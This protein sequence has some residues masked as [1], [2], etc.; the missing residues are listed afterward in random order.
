MKQ[1]FKNII[2]GYRSELLNGKFNLLENRFLTQPGESLI[3]AS[4]RLG[5]FDLGELKTLNKTFNEKDKSLPQIVRTAG[6][7]EK[8]SPEVKLIIKALEAL[9]YQVRKED[10]KNYNLNIVGIRNDEVKLNQFNDELWVFWKFENVWKL[11]KYKITTNPG[12][13]W[14][15]NPMN[16]EGT[17]ILKEGQY[18]DSHIF[19]KHKGKYEALVQSKPLTVIRDTNRDTTVDFNSNKTQTGKFGIN[20]HRSNENHES[21]SVDKWS[22]GCQVFARPKE[23]NDFIKLCKLY[24]AEWENTFTYTLIRKSDLK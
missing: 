16:K 14:L 6:E 5:I 7:P 11:N 1:P 21:T 17:A 19:G 8:L 13:F 22:A 4:N 18:L 15:T 23:F 12:L 9:K 10:F 24:M 20:I 3:E 2:E